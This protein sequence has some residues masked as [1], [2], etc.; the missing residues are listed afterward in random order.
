MT[1]MSAQKYEELGEGG[2]GGKR[3]WKEQRGRGAISKKKK[4]SQKREPYAAGRD[5]QREKTP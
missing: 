1:K 4:V 2:G 3:C 5:K